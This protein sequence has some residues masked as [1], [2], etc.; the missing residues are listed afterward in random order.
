M[1]LIIDKGIAMDNY[2]NIYGI[3]KLDDWATSVF[4]KNGRQAYIEIKRLNANFTASVYHFWKDDIRE[5]KLIKELGKHDE[6][7]ACLQE[8]MGWVDEH[9]AQFLKP[10]EI[11]KDVRYK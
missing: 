1:V 7:T 2:K 11:K 9:S 6:A 10:E 4:L 5:R 8:A 3:E